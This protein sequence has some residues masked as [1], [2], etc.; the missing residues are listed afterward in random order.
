M[1]CI[2][3]AEAQTFAQIRIFLIRLAGP[4]WA[5]LLAMPHAGRCMVRR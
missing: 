1:Y 2:T 3:D 5:A 4:R